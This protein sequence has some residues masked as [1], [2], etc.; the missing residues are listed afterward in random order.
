MYQKLI[1]K[2]AM[3]LLL[4]LVAGAAFAQ[5]VWIDEKGIRQYS[6][7]PPPAS[8]AKNRILKNPVM[9]PR[10]SRPEADVPASAEAGQVGNTAP[11]VQKLPPTTAEKNADYLKRKSEQADKDKKA[12]DDAREAT[13][14]AANCDRLQ[15]YTRTLQSGE[16]VASTDKNGERTFLSND[17]R[18]Q[19]LTDSRR[20][21]EGCK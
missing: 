9:E 20:A 12:A 19:E 2:T 1:R 16:R 13:A 18:A 14:K 10:N 17:K 11:P 6:D 5:F 21:L 8:V 15:A 3:A 4:N 7:Q